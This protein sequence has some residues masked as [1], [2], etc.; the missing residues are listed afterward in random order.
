M[1]L[2]TDT[3]DAKYFP[4]CSQVVDVPKPKG[5]VCTALSQQLKHRKALTYSRFVEI[6]IDKIYSG[7]RVALKTPLC[8]TWYEVVSKLLSLQGEKLSVKHPNLHGW[9]NRSELDS[10]SWQQLTHK[11]LWDGEGS[12]VTGAGHRVAAP[13]FSIQ[14]IE[15]NVLSVEDSV[16]FQVSDPE[17]LG[18]IEDTTSF[19]AN[20]AGSWVENQS[21]QSPFFTRHFKSTRI[22]LLSGWNQK[23][24]RLKRVQYLSADSPCFCV[25]RE[26]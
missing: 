15:G 7:N 8:L 1:F 4:Y 25:N 20:S 21:S 18:I 2:V 10:S 16:G 23:F 9:N 24:W 13:V 14:T 26:L 6:Y 12:I 22:T 5:T 17:L 19:D 3:R 11:A